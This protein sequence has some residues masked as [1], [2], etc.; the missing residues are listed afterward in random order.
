MT[1]WRR[2]LLALGP[3][4]SRLLLW[5]VSQ[6]RVRT[7]AIGP[8]VVSG[9]VRHNAPAF[10]T[11]TETTV[12][13]ETST[14]EKP[15]RN[16]LTEILAPTHWTD[17]YQCGKCTAGCPVAAAVD[18]APNQIVR[19]LQLGNFEKAMTS[20]AIW[21]CV[22]C[23]T[24]STRCPQSVDCAGIMDALREVSLQ[25]GLASPAQKTVVAFQQAFLKNIQ[26]NGRLDEI[27]LIAEFKLRALPSQRS[28]RFLFKD[29]G[30]APQLQIRRKLH[31]RGEKVKDRALVRRI[32]E[33]CADGR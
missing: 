23:Q 4:S 6:S 30:L 26:R 20:D 31:L 27:E 1:I 9:T 7:I 29:A 25:R 10:A 32:F 12:P 15:S 13:V 8:R 17:C 11:P 24:C 16:V 18:L 22:S 28:L 2:D 33:R 3:Y 21:T 5:P 19:A 14:C